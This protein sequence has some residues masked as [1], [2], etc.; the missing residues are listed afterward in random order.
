MAGHFPGLRVP[1]GPR[2][3]GAYDS[4]PLFGPPFCGRRR[5]AAV[6]RRRLLPPGFCQENIMDEKSVEEKQ[7]EMLAMAGKMERMIQE[8][9]NDLKETEETFRR[10]AP[11]LGIF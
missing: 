3:V 5:G 10:L 6:F 7:R 1:R 2:Q 9:T 8:M 4:R 11:L